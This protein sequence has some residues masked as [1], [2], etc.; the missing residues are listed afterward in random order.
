MRSVFA[1]FFFMAACALPVCAQQKDP[2]QQPESPHD[3]WLVRSQTITDDLIRDSAALTSLE[4]TTLWA[5]LAQRWWR[6]DPEKSRAW[7]LK[8]IAAVEAVP[9]RENPTERSQRLSTA[10][11]L[12]NIVTPLDQKLSKRLAAV[13]SDDAEHMADAERA[14]NADGLIEAAMSLVDKEPLR[15]AELGTLALRIGAPPQIVWLI[16]RLRRKEAGLA[17]SLYAQTIEIARQTMNQELINSLTQMTFPESMEPG[18]QAGGLPDELRT[19]LLKLDIVFLQAN[20]ISAENR[21]S[22]C[23]SVTAFIGPVLTH[24]DRLL[25]QQAA[26]ARQSVSQCQAST[27]P[28]IRQRAEDALRDQPLKTVDDLLKAAD[29]AQNVKVST[30]Y[31]YRAAALAKEQNDLDRALKILDSMTAEARELMGGSWEAYRWQW[32]ALAALN[33]FRS[34]DIYGMRLV[35]N[36]A[37]ADLRPFVLIAI[38]SQLPPNNDKGI[39]PALQLLDEARTSLRRSSVPDAE[40]WSWYF[41]LLQLTVKYQPEQAN[42]ALKDAVAALNRAEQAK[43]KDSAQDKNK[44]SSLD[45]SEISRTLPA[46]LLEMDEYAVKEAVSSITSPYTRT[47]V[48]LELLNVCL[49]RLR[50]SKPS[51]PSPKPAISSG[52]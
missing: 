44:T 34:G 14:A 20:P 11:L 8:A 33:H 38:V 42:A 32:G 15:A 17:D 16:S 29:D 46:S 24:F 23:T 51:P 7:M 25:P 22:I 27:S 18:I 35:I 1:C 10:R 5:R 50:S 2:G 40:K 47:Q 6:E 28:Q 39:N 43:E 26:F 3:L 13:L 37:P 49:Q 48:R 21:G 36:G 31:L 19:E 4:Q 12:L 45:T 41:E 9:N 52:E 30:L